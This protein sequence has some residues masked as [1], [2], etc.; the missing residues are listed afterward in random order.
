M[1]FVWSIV[2][3]LLSVSSPALALTAYRDS[4]EN[5]YFTGS[6]LPPNAAVSISY[7]GASTRYQEVQMYRHPA[8][9]CPVHRLW[10]SSKFRFFL[11]MSSYVLTLSNTPAGNIS[12]RPN[13]LSKAADN[14]NPCNGSSIRSDLPW[15]ELK[16]GSGIKAI[17]LIDTSRF[18][19]YWK[20][21]RTTVPIST[22]TVY[23]IGLPANAYQA[24]NVQV[25]ERFT[26]VNQCGILKLS[27]TVKWKPR[28]DDQGYLT[29][30][31]NRSE[32]S[33]RFRR[34]T[35]TIKPDKQIPKCFG[36]RLFLPT[37]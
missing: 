15:T 3:L 22:Q 7:D 24:T 29:V 19:F 20:R 18:K 11:D 10:G 31:I 21:K 5:L 17:G 30:T 13:S 2:A 37:P 1:K 35:A 4:K 25:R 34:S 6:E 12:F 14:T 33:Y 9:P 8:L 23:V 28:A 16:A 27:S 32:K 26:R 36:G